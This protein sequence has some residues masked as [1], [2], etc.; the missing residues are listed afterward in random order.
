MEE[1]WLPATSPDRIILQVLELRM[2]V[3]VRHFISFGLMRLLSAE[4]S[5]PA[6]DTEPSEFPLSR[7]LVMVMPL[8]LPLISLGS[9]QF[10]WLI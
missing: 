2:E 9:N 1:L 7:Y 4:K 10:V 3:W 8:V 6:I 5:F